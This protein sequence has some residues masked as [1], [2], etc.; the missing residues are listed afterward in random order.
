MPRTRQ[1]DYSDRG[2][3]RRI[4]RIAKEALGLQF[5]KI[6]QSGSQANLAGLRSERILFSERLD[7]RTYFVQNTN[8][9][10]GKADGVFSGTDHEQFRA[11]RRIV[12]RLGIPLSEIAEQVVL[13]EQGRT[14]QMDEYGKV[15]E[16]GEVQPGR[17]FVRLLRQIDRVPV[18]SS[19]VVLGLT[20]NK[21][22][23]FL[24]LHW[25]MVP[26]HTMIEARRLA[27]KVCHG[28]SLPERRGTVILSAQAGIIHSPAA[29]T[30]MDIYPVIRVIY[31][32]KDSESGKKLVLCFDRHGH[33]T[34]LP[35]QVELPLEPPQKKRPEE[36][37]GSS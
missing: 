37:V 18:W 34:P 28:W 4:T 5:D 21:Q 22:I 12:R 8:Y 31:A 2:E 11:C 14:A 19:N 36:G 32:P 20:A 13:R 29:G 10:L 30:F 27:Y 15:I 7:C 1:K 26:D 35:R 23:G 9:G 6:V 24:Q 25:P 16:M 17:S 3:I 33:R